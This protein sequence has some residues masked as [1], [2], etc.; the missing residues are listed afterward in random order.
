M[1][2]AASQDAQEA[3]VATLERRLADAMGDV[4]T[5]LCRLDA[6]LRG[7]ELGSGLMVEARPR[8]GEP[9]AEPLRSGPAMSVRS[10]VSA[11]A[12]DHDRASASRAASRLRSG[13]SLGDLVGGRILA[14]LGGAATLLGIVLF[15]GLAISH[16]WIGQE[17]RILL[18]VAASTALLAAGAWLHEHRGR[19]EAAIVMVG[20]A[21]AGLFATLIV[22]SGVYHL[23]PGI[24]AVVGSMLVGALATVLAIR[25]AGR[26]IG[27]LGL[28][29]ALLSPVLVGAPA[30]LTTVAALLVIAACAMYVVV[31]QRWGWLALGTVIICAPQ[32]ATW[33]LA[34]RPALL[35]VLVLALFA[36]LGLMGAI[37]AQLRSAQERLLPASAAVVA[38]SA[39]LVAVVGRVALAEAAG[40][41]AGNLWLVALAGVHLIAGAQRFRRAPISLRLRLVLIA[42]GIAL[43]DVAFGLSAHG[44]SLALGWSASA[45]AF[46][47]L[48]R[49]TARDHAGQRL[50]ELGVGVQIALA[51]IRVLIDAP[52]SDLASGHPQLLPLLSVSALAAGC[53]ACG[54]MGAAERT[55]W[56]IALNGLGLLAIAY[57]TASA[58]DGAALA[59]A[60]AFEGLALIQLDSR[61]D[62]VVTRLGGLAFVGAAAVHVLVADA[63]P[64]ALTAGAANLGAAVIALGALACVGLRVGLS[65]PS[66]TPRRQWPLMGAAGAVL[67]LASVAMITIFQ[68][69]TATVTALV[70]DLT[71]RQ[72]GQVALSSLWSLVGVAA[73]IVGLRRNIVL[74]RSAGLALLLLTVG[75]V[76][77]YD[78]SILTSVYRVSSFIV[79]GL[80][81]LLGA[82]A[83]QRL[84]PPPLPDMRTLHPSQR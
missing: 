12:R 48:A 58:V 36:A 63:P 69:T 43:A 20:T 49:G 17:A 60:W 24:V 44:V 10:A 11:Q 2:A 71:V 68:P 7:L 80:L 45:V 15:L 78:L 31:W 70:L 52:P 74:V 54:L 38:L 79:L 59:A 22:A 32:W 72:Q 65:Q 39:C 14:W 28:M 51:L 34:G 84:R 83:Y 42:V 35:D 33:L 73:L 27:G 53:I 6:R 75:K 57:L 50:C 25:W 46:A 41:A 19:T 66:G 62:D 18:A 47:W 21:T 16:G 40:T 82:F 13:I 30:N 8:H 77:L 56:R 3:R 61:T 29:G 81:L 1:N 55:T 37:G 64:S 5:H 76:F 26:A 4:D 67:Y 9:S 23:L